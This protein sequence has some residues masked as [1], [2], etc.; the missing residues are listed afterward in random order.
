M[1]RRAWRSVNGIVLAAA[2][3]LGGCGEGL[4]FRQDDRLELR[5]PDTGAEVTLPFTVSWTMEDFDLIGPGTQRRDDG[6]Y[7]V[8]FLDRSPMAPGASIRSLFDED[9]CAGDPCPSVEEMHASDVYPVEDGTSVEIARL[10]DPS[11]GG[12]EERHELT[13]VLVDP[14]G[15]RIGENSWSRT[16]TFHRKGA[17]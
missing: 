15:R 10:A 9:D 1:R 5:S 16:F 6:G 11:G 4:S 3:A 13:V 12:G 7:F 2:L 8:V 14:T 17:N